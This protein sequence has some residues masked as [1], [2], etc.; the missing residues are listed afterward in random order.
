[1]GAS[2]ALAI[3]ARGSGEGVGKR[4]HSLPDADRHGAGVGPHSQRTG[5]GHGSD[6]HRSAGLGPSDPRA[7]NVPLGHGGWPERG[8]QICK[9]R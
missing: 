4:K 2:T 5:H 6:E 7:G 8:D 9:A 1:M 3:V